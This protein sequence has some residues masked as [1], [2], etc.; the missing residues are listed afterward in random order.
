MLLQEQEHIMASRGDENYL[1]G[2]LERGLEALLAFIHQPEMSFSAFVKATGLNKATAKRILYTLE[3]N[4][5]IRFSLATNTYSLGIKVFELGTVAAENNPLL[6]VARPY[7]ESLCNQVNETVLMA[8]KVGCEQIYVHKIEGEGTVRLQ[9]FIGHR[10]PLYYGLGKTILAF[11]PEDEQMRILPE[12]IPYY[13]IKTLPFREQFLE[14]LQQIRQRGYAVDN[15]EYIEGVIGIGFPL[16]RN[17]K[18]VIGLVGLVTP[19][20]RMTCEKQELV[21]RLLGKASQVISRKLVDCFDLR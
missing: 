14:E 21:V 16:F 12:T 9:T 8:K 6:K 20:K 18:E 2:G 15:E 4:E 7:M 5:F 17:E 19:T 11:L 13:R 1:V 3:K 10:R